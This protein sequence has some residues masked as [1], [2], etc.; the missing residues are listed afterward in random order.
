MGNLNKNQLNSSNKEETKEKGYQKH[1]LVDGKFLIKKKIGSG[2]FGQIHRCVRLSDKKIFAVKFGTE[3]GIGQLEYESKMYKILK[4]NIGISNIQHFGK[5]KYENF[6]IMDYLGSNLESLFKY[7]GRKFS[8]KTVLMI[9]DQILCRLQLLHTK[10]IVY[11]DIKPENF[12]IGRGKNKDQIYIID[13]GLSKLYRNFWTH[14]PNKYRNKRDLV[15]TVRYSSINTHLGIEQSRRDDLESFGYMLI[16]LLKG[17]LPWQGFKAS[18]KKKRNEKICDKKVSTPLSTLCEGLP[19]E[20]KQFI[21][22]CK[23]LEFEESP[24]Y[25]YLRK[26]FRKLFLSNGYVY[27]HQYDWKIKHDKESKIKKDTSKN[28]GFYNEK[29]INGEINQTKIISNKPIKKNK[30]NQ[31]NSNRSST[32]RGNTNNSGHN[33]NTNKKS[34]KRN[35]KEQ[36]DKKQKSKSKLNSKS[37][38]KNKNKNQNINKNQNKK[39]NKNKRMILIKESGSENETNTEDEFKKKN[40]SKKEKK[41]Q[42]NIQKSKKLKEMDERIQFYNKKQNKKIKVKIENY[43]LKK[44]K[45]PKMDESK[46]E[47]TENFFLCIGEQYSLKRREMHQDLKNVDKILKHNP[48][49]KDIVIEELINSLKSALSG[50]LTYNYFLFLENDLLQLL[51]IVDEKKNKYE[52]MCNSNDLKFINNNEKKKKGGRGEKKDDFVFKPK[53]H[54]LGRKEKRKQ[55]KRWRN[56]RQVKKTI[57]VNEKLIILEK[58]LQI[59]EIREDI[60]IQDQ[61]QKIVP[62]ST[63]N[64]SFKKLEKLCNKIEKVL[65]LSKEKID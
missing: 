16:Y 63:K 54:K 39:Q 23:K 14:K 15:G 52:L 12:V 38:I 56:E 17:R 25:S 22:Y 43:L 19:D 26:K 53:K 59:K 7:C 4:G 51:Y 46:K 11:R 40:K 27:D 33:H 42:K 6:L 62:L 57:L 58:V 10:S 24:N 35:N 29:Q 61:Y 31:N 9:A 45:I 1:F 3:R 41:K 20:F 55:K 28:Q 36:Y 32:D 37:N 60:L 50:S 13:F 64:L 44:Q 65:I 18:N 8:L 48:T 30:S 21:E 5:Y 49:F 2:S 34:N 47:R